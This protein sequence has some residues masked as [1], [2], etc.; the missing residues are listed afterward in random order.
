MIVDAIAGHASETPPAWL[1]VGA[2]WFHIM[3]VGVWI[4]GLGWLA[5]RS[6]VERIPIGPGW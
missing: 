5:W 3:S 1:N 4:G 6:G 2:E